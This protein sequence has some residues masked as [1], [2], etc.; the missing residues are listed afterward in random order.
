AKS[1]RDSAVGLA[2]LSVPASLAADNL[3]L[4]NALMRM[5]G[6][7]SDFARVNDDP[8]AAML[9]LQ[10]YSQANQDLA[11]AFTN[12]GNDYAA[13]G[14]VLHDGEPGAAFVNFIAN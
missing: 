7:I 9:A 11:T 10:Q 8:L 2:A 12:I 13:S 4:L 14:I 5:G 1:N 6:I 3:S